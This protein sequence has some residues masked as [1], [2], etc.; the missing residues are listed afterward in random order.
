M[1]VEGE[2]APVAAVIHP[3]RKTSAKTPKTLLK[4]NNCVVFINRQ[5]Q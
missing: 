5:I 3:E 1:T 4:F 2:V